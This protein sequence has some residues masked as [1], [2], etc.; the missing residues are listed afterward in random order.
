MVDKGILNMDDIHQVWSSKL[1]PN[2]PIVMPASLPQEARD[3][4]VGM[5]E[6]L[7]ENDPKCNENVAAGQVRAWVPVD[8]TFYESIIKARKAKLESGS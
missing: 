7:I 2:G 6:W 8:E 5:K 1:I 3:V 4:M